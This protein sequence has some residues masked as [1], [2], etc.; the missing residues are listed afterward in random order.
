MF[1]RSEIE[2]GLESTF[3]NC[4][5]KECFGGIVQKH[6]VQ[7]NFLPSVTLGLHFTKYHWSQHIKNRTLLRFS[8]IKNWNLKESL[9]ELA[10]L[11]GKV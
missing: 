3:Q 7:R 2:D 6:V 1:Y 9:L 8:Y 5:F 11:N 10:A 4:G